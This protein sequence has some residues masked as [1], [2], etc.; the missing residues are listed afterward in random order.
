[1]KTS[2][3]IIDDHQ[4]FN[5]GLALILKESKD[6]R[7]VG[8]VY[9]SRDALYQFQVLNPDLVLVDFN[10]PYLDGLQVV[11]QLNT[12]NHK[13]KVVVISMYADS[14]EILLFKEL[15]VNG[16]LPKTT[17]AKELRE[18]LREIMTGKLVFKSLKAEKATVAKDSFALK[19]HL[20]KREIEIL[21]ALKQGNTTE[22][23][24]Q[25]LNLS[26]F[27]VETHR[28]NINQKLNFKNKQEFYDFLKEMNP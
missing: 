28:K 21:K 13:C 4:L 22:Q 5:D 7:I 27:T 3:L 10:M 12:L 8:Q 23:V 26:F 15:E 19:Y 2:I 6:F 9:D 17:P 24:A 20:S 14:K 18:A 1:M 11:K 25:L 16:Y